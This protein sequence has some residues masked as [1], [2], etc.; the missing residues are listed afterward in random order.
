ALLQPLE[1]RAIAG[2]LAAPR[3]VL[4]R[5]PRQRRRLRRLRVERAERLLLLLA[6]RFELARR[7]VDGTGNFDLEALRDE[8]HGL[9]DLRPLR[10]ARSVLRRQL[11]VA[12]A[13][14][15]ELRR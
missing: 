1:Q 13:Q 10:M 7:R 15:G 2:D 3:V 6:R 5:A 11:G 9:L 12:P 4:G 8:R 14:P